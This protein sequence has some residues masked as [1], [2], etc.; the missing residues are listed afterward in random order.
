MEEGMGGGESAGT[1]SSF[2]SVGGRQRFTVELRPGETTIVS[3]KKLV[4]DTTKVAVP[5][6]VP[7]PPANAHPA[8]EARLDPGQTVENEVQDAPPS[9]RFSAVIE[10][11][12]RL[13]MGKHSSDE[14]D[15]N[16][17]PDDDEYDT[18]DSFIDDTEL[19]EY[20]QVDNSAIKHDGFFVN[21][22]KLERINEFTSLPNQQPKKRRRK[23]VAK[24]H[25]E[26]DDGRV[27]NKHLKVEK[28]AAGKS[29]PLVGKNTT[30][31]AHVV[32]LPSGPH[33]DMK[34]QNQKNSS[35]VG[36]KNKS[37]ETKTS[38]D[39]TPSKVSNGDASLSLVVEKDIDKQ[40]TGIAPSMY[41]GNKLKNGGEVSDASVQR[42]HDKSSHAQSKSQSGK[43]SNNFDE[44][45]QAVHWREKDGSRERPDLNGTEGKYSKQI[46][47]TPVMQRKE[48]SSVRS[49]STML[50]KA[51][52]ELEKMVSDSRPPALE[53]QDADI[54]SQAVK[55]RLPREVKQKLA[56][57]ARVAQANHGKISKELVNRLMSML[58]HM[59]Q[60]R[61]LKRN[62]KD[63]VN[64]GLLAKKEKDDRFQ[65]MKKEV[66]DLIRVR[67]PYIMSKALEQQAGASDDF[68]EIGNEVI[69]RKCSMDDVLED[70]I[71]GL[72][73]LYV[74]GL[75][76]DASPQ[77][78]KLYAELAALWPDGFMDNH[79]IKRAICRAKDRKRA[80]YRQ[81]KDQEKVNRKKLIP[82]TE[83][84][85][86]AETTSIAQPQYTQEKLVI[87]SNNHGSTSLVRPVPSATATN[88]STRVPSTSLSGP[89]LERPR[90]EKVK[91]SSSN[92]NETRTMDALTK[93]KVKRKPESELGE[94]HFRPEKVGSAPGEER[95]KPR[96][97][98]FAPP[99]K[100]SLPI[101]VAP[102][103]PSQNFDQ[104]S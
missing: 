12:E 13:Y 16:D 9:S 54:S 60:L 30:V 11:I 56:K 32:A 44:F 2:V 71:C 93:K 67:V 62:L 75:D 65:Q 51:I 79:G 99:P 7:E 10:K 87:D 6:S 29:G 35:V 18:E 85:V 76:E 37:A 48:S 97:Q 96:K 17:V 41:Q 38:V 43:L 33:M 88:A 3:W 70:R 84:N 102:P 28:K 25:G 31:P 8:L 83:E 45:N 50:E 91:G 40:K 90:L 82:K 26:G 53:A 94:A 100:P 39:P 1:S 57:V 104:P 20:F 49:K 24:G 69:K 92:P 34:F 59:M 14:E 21:R 81:H 15:L 52:K 5:T 68:Q 98:V 80:L 74:E 61:T 23:D 63:M 64:I 22:G 4:K 86:R 72:Y 95:H 103:L 66:A 58:G 89:T 36:A 27:P 101:V 55:R 46:T 19:D 73:D 77:V 78:R 42:S 47:K